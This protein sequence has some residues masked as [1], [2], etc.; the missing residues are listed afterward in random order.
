MD[1]AA[2]M[3]GSRAATFSSSAP[4]ANPSVV[5]VPLSLAVEIVA[6]AERAKGTAQP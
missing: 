3:T 2:S 5:V 6:M 4:T 1:L